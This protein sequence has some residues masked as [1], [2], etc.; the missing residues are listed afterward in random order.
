M[1]LRT[2]KQVLPTSPLVIEAEDHRYVQ[3]MQVLCPRGGDIDARADIMPEIK[4]RIQLAR[5]CY[6]PFRRELY[7]MQDALFT[8]QVHQ[9][10]TEVK[11]TVLYGCVT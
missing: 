1:L 8:L 5:A 6:D 3:T 2:L 10:K 4:R 7:D 11:E 9:V